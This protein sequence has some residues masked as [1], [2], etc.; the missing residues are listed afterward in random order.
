LKL[1]AWNEKSGKMLGDKA[2]H[3][4]KKTP[5]GEGSEFFLKPN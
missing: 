3:F 4:Q 1:I 5:L 2:Y